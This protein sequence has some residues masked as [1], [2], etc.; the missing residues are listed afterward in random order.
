MNEDCDHYSYECYYGTHYCADCK[1]C[2]GTD[3]E[4]LH[5]H[6]AKECDICGPT[7]VHHGIP[8]T[9]QH[10]CA[11]KYPSVAERM[12]PAGKVFVTKDSGQRYTFDSGM[13]RDT[14]DGKARFDL[15]FPKDVPYE[16]QF[17]TRVAELLARGAEKYAERNWEQAEGMV[18]MER[19]KAS[20]MRHLAQWMAGEEDE[21]HAAAVV[22][23]LLGAETLKWKMDQNEDPTR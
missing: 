12:V 18:E 17:L 3:E 21:D 9:V 8:C 7:A 23:N 5:P 1:E 20:A 22:F 15:L 4:P 2:L 11:Y 6:S 10:P 16:G 19:F 14:Q 13:Q